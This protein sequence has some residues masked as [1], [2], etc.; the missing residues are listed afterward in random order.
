MKDH[1]R[2]IYKPEKK[3]YARFFFSSWR[4][5]DADLK[6]AKTTRE[7]FVELLCKGVDEV[8]AENE[9]KG[10]WWSFLPLAS[11]VWALTITAWLFYFL[12]ISIVYMIP[13]VLNTNE[14]NKIENNMMDMLAM[15]L[16]P[17]LVAALNYW[18]PYGV[19]YL[20]YIYKDNRASTQYKYFIARYYATKWLGYGFTL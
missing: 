18:C 14:T 9:P 19:A 16:V 12:L 17:I 5:D 8:G 13:G 4:W 6:H 10:K 1:I 2:Q 15:I 3:E 7:R 11:G 20:T